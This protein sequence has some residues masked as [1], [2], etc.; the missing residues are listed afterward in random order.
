M[1]GFHEP[2]AFLSWKITSGDQFSL[3][4]K[5]TPEEKKKGQRLYCQE[6]LTQKCLN[7]HL[8]EVNVTIKSAL[9]ATDKNNYYGCPEKTNIYP[10]QAD[11]WPLAS[12]PGCKQQRSNREQV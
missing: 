5:Q 6:Y 2:L 11:I 7:Q 12:A 4:A 1:H 8:E 3:F 9:R 10:R